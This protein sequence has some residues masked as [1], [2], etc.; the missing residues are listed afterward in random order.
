AAPR[1]GG[2]REAPRAA[3]LHGGEDGRGVRPTLRLAGRGARDRGPMIRRGLFNAYA[4]LRAR[5]VLGYLEQLEITQWLSPEQ[6][7]LL[8]ARKRRAILEHAGSS[9]PYY[10]EL[11]RRVR[12]NPSAVTSVDDLEAL[13]I[14]EREVLSQRFEEMRASGAEMSIERAT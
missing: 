9:V 8:Q 4:Y 6:V 10:R 14:L 11:F 3:P 12:F 7:S 13:P 5:D 2:G 1:D